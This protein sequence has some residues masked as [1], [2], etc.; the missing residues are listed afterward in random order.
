KLDNN[1]READRRVALARWITA[2]GNPLP[3]RVIVNRLWGWHFG[4]GLVR[5]PSDFRFQGGLPSHPELLDWLAGQL[6]N[7]ADGPAWR[8]KRIQ[9]AIVTSATYRQSSR[10]V[11]KAMKLDAGNDLVWRRPPHR[12]EAETFRDTVLAV[13][14]QLDRRIGGP[15]FRDYTVS[16]V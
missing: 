5:T 12:L 13:S 2:P 9:R 6:A 15:G 8:L 3:A 16:S 7:P 14:G 1:A 4:R 10:A 11:P